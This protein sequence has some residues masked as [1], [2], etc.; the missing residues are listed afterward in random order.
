MKEKPPG[1]NEF[2]K[3]STEV[4]VPEYL[5]AKNFRKQIIMGYGEDVNWGP[6]GELENK[7]K[8]SKPKWNK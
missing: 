6:L 5:I 4:N 7:R 3:G 8:R 2:Y 1:M